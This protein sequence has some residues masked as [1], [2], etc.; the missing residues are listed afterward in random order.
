MDGSNLF[1]LF[2]QGQPFSIL[3]KIILE[4]FLDF[5]ILNKVRHED[6]WFD[7]T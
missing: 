1:T 2:Y 4:W 7:T 5:I 3:R 6:I